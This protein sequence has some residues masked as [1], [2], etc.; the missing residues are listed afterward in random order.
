MIMLA[1][2][3]DVDQEGE[4]DESPSKKPKKDKEEL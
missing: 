4:A 3:L 2:C 1:D